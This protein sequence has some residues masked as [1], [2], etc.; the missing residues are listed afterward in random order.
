[1]LNNNQS[2]SNSLEA[3]LTPLQLAALFLMRPAKDSMVALADVPIV[4]DNT[5]LGDTISCMSRSRLGYALV[6]S[7]EAKPCRLI[8]E[9]NLLHEVV[10]ALLENNS[11]IS[12]VF[13]LP[14][15]NFSREADTIHSES[16]LLYA[17]RKMRDAGH[18]R[19]VINNNKTDN[20]IGIISEESII[21]KH[22]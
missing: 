4:A 22:L 16:S 14:T 19:I 21:K 18:R 13:K 12:Q 6:K 20:P 17:V 10:P 5:L 8:T 3:K 15:G 1:M 9:R 2:T 7:Q 11:D